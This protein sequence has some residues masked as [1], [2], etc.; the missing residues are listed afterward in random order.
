MYKQDLINNKIQQKREDI[1][2]Q[3]QRSNSQS[4][5]DNSKEYHSAQQQRPQTQL[6]QKGAPEYRRFQNL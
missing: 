3:M 6:A 5:I 1:F 2:R 4:Q